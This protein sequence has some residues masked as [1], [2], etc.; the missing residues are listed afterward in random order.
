[1]LDL[2]II[3]AGLSGLSA[4]LVAAQAGKR[5][6]VVAKGLGAM[7]WSAA[8]IDV[9]GYLPVTDK[10]P[11]AEPVTQPLAAI[12]KLPP[13]HPYHLISATDRQDSLALFQQILTDAGLPYL[14]APESG[15]NLLLPSPV[16]AVRPVFLAPQAQHGGHLDHDQPILIVGFD[17]MRDFYPALIAE[18]LGKQGYA[19]RFTQLPLDVITSRS[20]ANTVQF[21]HAIDS[22]PVLNRLGAALAKLVRPNERIG[23][24]A[25]LGLDRHAEVMDFL[26]ERTDATVFEIPTLPPSV[27]GIRMHTLL[28]TTLLSH[29][30]RV[31]A[32]MEII[33]FHAD[34]GQI[35]W[36]ASE[37]SARPLKHRAKQFLLATGGVLGGGFDSAPDGRFWETIFNLPLT[38]E[39]DRNKWFRP[40]FLDPAGQPVFSGGVAVNDELQPVDASGDPVYSNLRAAGSV[41]AHADPIQER[42]LEG[43][44]IITGMMAARAITFGIR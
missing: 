35:R 19:V 18:N 27:P 9:L 39:Q 37:T 36:V 23:L 24:P 33:D 32:G 22:S 38:V 16:G 44:S 28:R 7:H 43:L 15:R 25:I 6:R 1:M 8:T 30:V 20:D 11:A 41:L 2:L 4:A 17:G 42:S 34:N 21:A 14:G 31:E 26:A 5:V 12:E 40:E 3:G 10:T 29:G 13:A